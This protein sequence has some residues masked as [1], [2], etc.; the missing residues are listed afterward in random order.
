MSDSAHAMPMANSM[1]Y[2]V[3]RYRNEFPIL[4]E[5]VHGKPLIFLDNAASAQKPQ[6]VIDAVRY[7]YEHEYANVHRGVHYM[8][9]K[10]TE[11]YEGAR[12]KVQRFIN[13]EHEHEVIFTRNATEAVNMVAGTFGRK[14]LEPGDEI[15]ISVMEHHANIVPWQ[16]LR[17]EKGLVLKAAPVSDDGEFLLDDFKKLLTQRTKLVAMTH[18]SNVLGTVTPAAE[19]AR[20]AHSVGAKVLFDGSQAAVHSPVDVQAIDCDFYVI[21]GHKLY[22]P[23]GVGVLYG[24]E[25]LLNAMPPYLGGGEMISKVTLA[26]STWAGLPNKF[27]AG[28]PMIAQAIGLGAAIDYILAIGMD[29]IAAHEQDLLGYTTQK[30]TSI[31]GLKIYGTAPNKAAVI[32]FS[33]ENAHPHDIAT[34]IDRGGVACRAGH[35]CA[36]PLMDRM[37]VTAMTRASFG[38]YN[39]R[40]DADALVET[41]EFTQE[42][43]G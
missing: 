35:H 40:A 2:D 41:L 31:P 24:K 32:S 5:Q 34:I 10:A 13:A 1:V 36:Q 23:S 9:E 7:V 11:A 19:I 21:T 18:T 33:M 37:G 28:T 30:L 29:R 25:E 8:S 43:L 27:E 42:F 12:G 16:M 38:L 39:T 26:E 4:S 6:Q 20:L 3:L 15:V 22:G 17:D 14:F